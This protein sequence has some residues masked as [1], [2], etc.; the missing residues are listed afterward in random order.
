M[1]KP[2]KYW[3][4]LSAAAVILACYAGMAWQ[5]EHP[6]DQL[7]AAVIDEVNKAEAVNFK[8]GLIVTRQRNGETMEEWQMKREGV[9]DVWHKNLHYRNVPQFSHL[10]GEEKKQVEQRTSLSP[11]EQGEITLLPVAEVRYENGVYREQ[12]RA[13]RAW[14]VRERAAYNILEILP[15][16]AELLNRYAK[17]YE[18]DNRGK[19]VVFFFSI[20]PEYLSRTFPA[21]LESYGYSFPPEFTEGT[22]KLLVYPDTLIP[23]RVYSIFRVTDPTTGE[24]YEFNLDTYFSASDS[25]TD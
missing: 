2:P 22:I 12:D 14:S 16:N 17:H 3:L 6:M 4:L 25:N 24:N 21:V 1:F 20:D 11:G 13:T 10:E 9:Y 19:F 18:S 15:F 23:R 8:S 5:R 7:Y